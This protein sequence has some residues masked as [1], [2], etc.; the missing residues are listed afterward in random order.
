MP[1]DSAQ[2]D[3]QPTETVEEKPSADALM[4]RLDEQSKRIDDMTGNLTRAEERATAAEKASAAPREEAPKSFTRAEM[5]RF[6]EGGQMTQAQADELHD[7]Q[8]ERTLDAKMQGEL[9]KRDAINQQAFSMTS[10]IDRYKD[11]VPDMMTNGSDARNK[12]QVEY[13]FLKSCGDVDGPTTEFKALRAA[14]GPVD[15]IA[16]RTKQRRETHVELSGSDFGASAPETGEGSLSA[17]NP[18]Q[19][20][21]YKKQIDAGYYTG[22]NDPA[23][24]KEAEHAK[25]IEQQRAARR[26][27]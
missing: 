24:L 11:L 26:V 3:P 6:V 21:Y 7:T 15:K 19:Q 22:P 17:F 4:A 10:Q 20:A 23:I 27:A 25:R 16:E 12:L 9:D 2:T 18:G 8:V 13:D 1:E 14:F 5:T